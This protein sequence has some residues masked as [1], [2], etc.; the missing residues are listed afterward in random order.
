[1]PETEARFSPASLSPQTAGTAETPCASLF[2]GELGP[3]RILEDRDVRRDGAGAGMDVSDG[4]VTVAGKACPQHGKARRGKTVLAGE[5]SGEAREPRDREAGCESHCAINEG[6]E[7]RCRNAGVGKSFMRALRKTMRANVTAE[8][9]NAPDLYAGPG[10][11]CGFVTFYGRCSSSSNGRSASRKGR[12][13]ASSGVTQRK[14]CPSLAAGS[15]ENS[16]M[17]KKWSRTA[18][19]P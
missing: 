10:R 9:R 15:P 4:A 6:E 13:R 14:S 2:C 8:K 3:D 18:R 19:K 12:V 1:M 5:S 17:W 11:C 16:V 7:R